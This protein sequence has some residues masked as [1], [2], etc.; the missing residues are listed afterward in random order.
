M[1]K[2]KRLF[3]FHKGQ[4]DESMKTAVEV[5][6]LKDIEL[7]VKDYFCD[8]GADVKYVE[9][10]TSPMNDED[11]LGCEWKD[12]YYVIGHT[13]DAQFVAG[14][15]NF[16]EDKTARDSTWKKYLWYAIYVLYL[17][18]VIYIFLIFAICGIIGYIGKIIYKKYFDPIFERIIY[19]CRLWD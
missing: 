16:Y 9:I 18:L 6:N 10:S 5:K 4:L 17:A 19:N 2:K 13:T 8:F 1:K 14:M 3:R 12:T 15:C 11:R 7:R